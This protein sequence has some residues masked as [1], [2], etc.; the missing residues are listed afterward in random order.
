MMTETFVLITEGSGIQFI[1]MKLSGCY[2]TEKSGII[3]DQKGFC[4]IDYSLMPNPDQLDER[5]FEEEFKIE[6]IGF[7]VRLACKF[8]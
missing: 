4:Q 3:W 1:W 2:E 8:L 5:W 7:W 6:W